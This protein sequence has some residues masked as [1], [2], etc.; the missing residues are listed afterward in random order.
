MQNKSHLTAISRS[1]LSAPMQY[2]LDNG[3]LYTTV[4]LDYGSGRG[5]DAD[6]IGMDK[7]DPHYTSGKIMEW[8]RDIHHDMLDMSSGYEV[9]TCNYVL[10]VIEDQAERDMVLL[11]IKMLLTD[12][13]KAY[14][15]VRRDSHIAEGYTSKGTYQATIELDLPVYHHAKGKYITYLL[16]K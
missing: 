12:T 16:E 8:D 10:N 14:I 5:H 7:F 4:G 6:H 9:I 3:A 11:N 13:G 1:K 15:T 2:L